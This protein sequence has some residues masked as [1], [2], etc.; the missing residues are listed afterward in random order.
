VAL[1]MKLAFLLLPV[2]ACAVEIG[3]VVTVTG[4]QIRGRS[5][6][7]GGAAF[8]GV[9]YARPPL[10]GLR[11]R[12]P[13]PVA[14]WT[15]I[16]EAGSFSPACTQLSEGWNIRS[17]QGSGEDC[18]Y[19]N[20]AAPVWP[21]A[22][23]VPAMV[24]IHGGSNTAGSGEA[25]GF[26]QRTLV[27]HGLVLVTINYRLGALG[28]LAH[29]ALARESAHHASGNYGL[30]DQIAALQWVRKNIATFGGDPERVTVA[31]QSAGAM[32][33]S[34]LMTSPLARGLF[35]GAI[36]E[37]GAVSIFNGS[38]TRG[39]A[40]ELGKKLA[41]ELK[42]P[43][44]DAIARLRQVQPVEILEAAKRATGG[45]RTGLETSVDGWVL[46]K[47]PAEVFAAGRSAAVPLLIGSTA[48]EIGGN[49][50][51][52]K[53][54]SA[55]QKAYGGLADRALALYGLAGG[56]EGKPDSLYGGPGVQWPTD[57]VFRCPV[58]AEA[59]AHAG[60][61]QT[62][63]QYG[64][65]H[66]A[67]DRPANH[68][69]GHSAE[70]NYVFGTWGSDVQLT[71]I[72]RKIAEQMQS[73]W[74]NFVLAGDPN[75][76]GLPSWPRFAVKER[77]YIAFTDDGAVVKTGLRREFCEVFIEHLQAGARR[78]AVPQQRP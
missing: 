9:P 14:A 54:G 23:K 5:T 20:V 57:E 15:G 72:D 49:E 31:G 76:E 17:V 22:A 38:R 63:Y 71:P 43:D 58:V 10:G 8:K 55:I 59:V 42:A 30:M 74:A 66:G 6:P 53:I 37:S 32:D 62:T 28:F 56:G 11:W 60:A 44:G 61:G 64:L 70:L 73:Y 39:E 35:R 4:G 52:A 34:L 47:P 21:P 27:R 33:V 2:F 3:P 46:P 1:N 16:R 29:P 25:A 26:D 77:K 41:V 48:Q 78:E 36:A 40:E 75:G 69:M 18:L 67:P 19:L 24:W 13:Q 65:D 7:D 45:D 12:E 51:A 50:S 68:G